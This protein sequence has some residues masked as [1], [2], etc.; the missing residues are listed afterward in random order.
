MGLLK[1]PI[2]INIV[3][4]VLGGSPA[5]PDHLNFIATHLP[6][7]AVWKT[8]P[9]SQATWPLTAMALGMGGNVRVGLEDNFYL[10]SGEMVKSNGELVAT[11]VAMARSA[12]RS[13]AT[14]DETKQILGLGR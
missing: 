5:T 13:P 12:G 11:A 7:G 8:T 14:V 10:P 1:G 6:K 4:G 3:L 2:D 9:I